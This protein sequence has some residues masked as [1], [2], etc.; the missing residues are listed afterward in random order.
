VWGER[1][2]EKRKEMRLKNMVDISEKTEKKSIRTTDENMEK[3]KQFA[4]DFEN[5]HLAFSRL[6]SMAEMDGARMA[7][8]GAQDMIDSFQGHLHGIEEAFVYSLKLK[9]DAERLAKEAVM[10][11]MESKDKTIADLQEKNEAQKAKFESLAAEVMETKEKLSVAIKNAQDAEKEA[12]RAESSLATANALVA[13]K[14]DEIAR[15]TVEAASAKEMKKENEALNAKV[16]EHEMSIMNMT[17]TVEDLKRENETIKKE[18]ERD[19]Q[20][21]KKEFE[22]AI[23]DMKKESESAKKEFERDIQNA[24]QIAENEKRA[25]VLEAKEEAQKKIDTYVE[26]LEA[27]DAEIAKLKSEL[28]ELKLMASKPSSVKKKEKKEEKKEEKEEEQQT[29]LEVES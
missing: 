19:L 2:K 8:P 17:R 14:N 13:A 11:T 26:K 20:I 3:F 7:M 25:A 15:L 24:K 16:S 10:R 6:L 4:A 23:S 21:A 9:E 12:H 22:R 18:S 29:T 28:V 1:N 27:K 5:Q